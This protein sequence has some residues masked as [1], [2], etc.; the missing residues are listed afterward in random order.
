MVTADASMIPG[1][2]ANQFTFNGKSNQAH[3]N[4]TMTEQSSFAPVASPVNPFQQ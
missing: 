2:T 3:S 4:T 1:Q